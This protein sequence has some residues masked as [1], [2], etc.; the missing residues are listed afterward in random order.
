MGKLSPIKGIGP[1]QLRTS[2]LV[3][4][5]KGGEIVEVILALSND[6]EEKPCHYLRSEVLNDQ[7]L[8][9]TRIGF[10]LPSGGITYADEHTLY[11]ALQSRKDID[12]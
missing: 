1:D 12:V 3:E 2:S 8:K 4:R 9:V 7:S 11:N 10:G 5:I 6:M